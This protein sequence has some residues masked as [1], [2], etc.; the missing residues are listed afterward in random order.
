[1]NF[2]SWVY[3]I[4]IL[5]GLVGSVA[6]VILT[7]KRGVPKNQKGTSPGQGGSLIVGGAGASSGEGGG[8]T[9]AY[10]ITKDPKE[11]ATAFVPNSAKEPKK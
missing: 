11:Y 4:A 10:V 8:T 9:R 5:L 7:L 6:I 3:V 2:E 1:M